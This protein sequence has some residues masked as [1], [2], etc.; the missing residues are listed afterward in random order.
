MTGNPWD[1]LD[2]Q[3]EAD[4]STEEDLEVIDP[5][6]QQR[7]HRA[8][9]VQP[10]D[11]SDQL[12]RFDAS[13]A[14]TLAWFVGVHGGSG[15]STLASWATGS[16]SGHRWPERSPSPVYL[17][18]RSNAK[19]LK[20]A[21]SALKDWSSGEIAV[22][23]SGLILMADS[24]GKVPRSLRGQISKLSGLIPEILRVPWVEGL[25]VEA[26]ASTVSAPKAVLKLITRLQA[27]LPEN[28]TD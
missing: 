28:G 9:G 12:G 1:L 4:Q 19:G 7:P 22:S 11:R 14:K 13:E 5:V 6:V 25:R 10:V 18:A 26:D 3:L 20:A 17:V 24:P 23:V 21:Q 8:Q 2:E 27:H 16:S 15:A